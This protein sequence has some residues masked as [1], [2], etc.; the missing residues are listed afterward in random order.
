MSC[1]H[2][3][4]SESFILFVNTRYI[5]G[6]SLLEINRISKI[7]NLDFLFATGSKFKQLE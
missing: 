5:M 6:K 2:E 7:K 4:L 1:L 3:K